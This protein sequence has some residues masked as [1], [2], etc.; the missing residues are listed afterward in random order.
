MYAP[1]KSNIGGGILYVNAGNFNKKIEIIKFCETKD[2]DGF[3]VKN[4]VLVLKAW[5]QITNI[6]GTE[7]IK[8]NSDFAE[9]KTRFLIR[10][11]NK[12]IE[13]DMFIKFR[14][15]FYIIT[16]INNYSFKGEYTEIIAELVQK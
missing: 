6:S 5:A 12:N 15:N 16:Y 9:T 11:S 13:K 8:S 14:S 3:P 10:T 2:K 4:E 1:K 7:L